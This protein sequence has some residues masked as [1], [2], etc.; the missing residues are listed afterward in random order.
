MQ[1]LSLLTSW[2]ISSVIQHSIAVHQLKPNAGTC[3]PGGRLVLFALEEQCSGVLAPRAWYISVQS[4]WWNELFMNKHHQTIMSCSYAS[5]FHGI[6]TGN[7]NNHFDSHLQ[8]QKFSALR[9]ES[10]AGASQ[11]SVTCCISYL[12]SITNGKSDC[13][14]S[15]WLFVSSVCYLTPHGYSNTYVCLFPTMISVWFPLA[16]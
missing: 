10:V 1:N 11:H 3:L 13:K 14:N 5:F 9:F 12:W 2:H 8:I 7:L 16:W 4:W 15:W 6:L